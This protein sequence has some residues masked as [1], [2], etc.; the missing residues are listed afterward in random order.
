MLQWIG[1]TPERQ[2]L[3]P[4]P[5]Y[6]A[7]PA[8]SMSDIETTDFQHPAEREFAQLLDFYGIRWEYE[9]HTFV[10]ERYEDGRLRV[11]FSPDFYLPD[12]DLYIELT[13][14]SPK[15]NHLKNRKI[16]KLKEL[17][18]E[19][20]IKL[21]SRRDLRSLALKYNLSDPTEPSHE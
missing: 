17:Y 9:P 4:V 11:A 2:R 14:Q 13:T 7:V 10:L 15:L 21:L 5:H 19:I 20:N 6:L 12:Q 1:E 16:R 3:H 8:Y 18:P